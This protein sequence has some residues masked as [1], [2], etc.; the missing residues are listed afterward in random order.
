MAWEDLPEILDHISDNWD[1]T[2][3]TWYDFAVQLDAA[4]LDY[5]LG[6]DHAALGHVLFALQEIE[7]TGDWVLSV[8]VSLS[9]KT[10]LMA[11]LKKMRTEYLAAG[12]EVTMDTILSAM[13][14]A[15]FDELQQFIGI[16]D[17]Y[18]V[19]LWN[20]PFNAEFYAALARGFTP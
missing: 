8:N 5:G 18:R 7:D 20:E 6:D 12:A 4:Q 13:I 17:A 16:V 2:P 14:T 9:P 10:M 1:Y 3:Y 11:C 15:D 19:S